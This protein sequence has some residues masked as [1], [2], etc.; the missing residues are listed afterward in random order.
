MTIRQLHENT[1][2]RD[3]VLGFLGSESQD[4]EW[5]TIL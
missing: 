5:A 3:A 1:V 2:V 4:R